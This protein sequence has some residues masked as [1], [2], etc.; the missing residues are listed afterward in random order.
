MKNYLR[1]FTSSTTLL[2]AKRRYR[3]LRNDMIFNITNFYFSD[4]RETIFT[5][6][7][8]AVYSGAFY[9]AKVHPDLQLYWCFIFISK[10]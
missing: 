10:Y 8:G 7:N 2:N 1:A 5:F 6:K 4:T 9:K 3:Y